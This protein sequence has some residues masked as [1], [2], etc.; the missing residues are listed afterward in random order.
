MAKILLTA[1][2]NRFYCRV[3]GR[4]IMM[5]EKYYRSIMRAFRASHTVNICTDCIRKMEAETRE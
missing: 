1:D 2:H 3:C 5:G 4:K